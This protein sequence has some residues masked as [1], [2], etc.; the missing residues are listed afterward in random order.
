M[1][2]HRPAMLIA[3][4][5]LSSLEIYASILD[6]WIASGIELHNVIYERYLLYREVCATEVI[7]FSMEDASRMNTCMPSLNG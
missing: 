6:N 5:N 4:T 1:S 3:F 7:E 2:P